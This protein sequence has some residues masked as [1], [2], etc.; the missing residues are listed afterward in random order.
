MSKPWKHAPQTVRRRSVG[1]PILWCL[2]ASAL[3]AVVV[4]R[5]G[6]ERWTPVATGPA[7][8]ATAYVV[9]GPRTSVPRGGENRVPFIHSDD[10]PERAAQAANSLAESDVSRRRAEWQRRTE[11]LIQN[12]LEAL[13][14]DALLA[15]WRASIPAAVYQETLLVLN[16]RLISPHEAVRKLVGS[17]N[18]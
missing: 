12:E 9:E 11:A 15:R 4:Y 10:D 8:T 18:S 2:L 17:Q 5:W 6:R 7:Y 1:V 13:L 16:Q 3:T 14:A